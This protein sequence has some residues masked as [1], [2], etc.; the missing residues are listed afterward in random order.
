MAIRLHDVFRWSGRTLL[1]SV[2]IF[3][4][5]ALVA[6]LAPPWHMGLYDTA[7][8]Q[9]RIVLFLM[10]PAALLW[11]ASGL[12]LHYRRKSAR[13]AGA[14]TRLDRIM[15]RLAPDERDYL[16]AKLDERLIGLGQDG[17]LQTLDDLLD[18]ANGN[19]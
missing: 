9:A 17:E 18:D 14:E 3:M 15:Q 16:Q 6:V 2:V 5:C 1:I 12:L 10:P 4:L 13:K 7:T 8:Y 19:H 11:A